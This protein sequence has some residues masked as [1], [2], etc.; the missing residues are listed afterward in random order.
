MRV[1]AGDIGGTT[2]R[3][4]LVD[5]AG[6]KATIVHREDYS[7]PKY[8]GLAPIVREYLTSIGETP[9]GACF[10]VPCPVGD[11]ACQLTNLKWTLE[12]SSFRRD[13]GL[14]GAM[15]INDFAA[16]GHA[17]PQ[18]TPDDL[19]SISAG[20][21]R[22]QAAI[23]MLGAGTGLGQG[24]MVWDGHRYRV[25][26]SEGGHVDFAARTEEE[27]G[28]LRFLQ[29]RHPRVSWERILSGRGILNIYE[30]LIAS[31]YGSENPAIRREM[32][33]ADPA[34]IISKHAVEGT[35]PVCRHVLDIFVSVYGAQA[36]NVALIY[37]ALGGIYLGGGIA[38][39]IVARLQGGEFLAA[40]RAKG[41]LSP[42]LL[43]IPI[44]VIIHPAP[45]LL[46]AARVAADPSLI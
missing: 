10:G 5:V 30:F 26:G 7:S 33:D 15:L 16:L 13:I 12:L 38:P 27:I 36:G 22:P 17:I 41:R 4:A 3:L 29:S 31:G 34:A 44:H 21:P 24:A 11:G 35:D 43:N 1:L 19:V 6:D 28:L 18:L 9:E 2:A 14:P 40:F 32:E 20:S 46:G 42:L 25:I 37:R 39:R 8:P 23:A 45:A